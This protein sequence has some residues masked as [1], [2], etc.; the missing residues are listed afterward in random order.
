MEITKDFQTWLI[1]YWSIEYLAHGWEV[2]PIHIKI[3]RTPEKDEKI[4]DGG[5]MFPWA[6][7]K[8]DIDVIVK[9]AKDLILSHGCFSGLMLICG[10]RSNCDVIDRDE[11]KQPCINRWI[12]DE[13]LKYVPYVVPKDLTQGNG[14]HYYF[15]HKPEHKTVKNS[16]YDIEVRSNGSLIV[17]PPSVVINPDGEN[18]SYQFTKY[19][20]FFEDHFP[21][22][23][24]PPLLYR[25]IAANSINK[26]PPKNVF[27]NPKATKKA[28]P[29]QKEHLKKL[30]AS[31]ID[32]RKGDDR[33]TKDYKFLIWAYKIGVDQDTARN[34]CVNTIKNKFEREDYFDQVWKGAVSAVETEDRRNMKK[35]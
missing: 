27:K 34:I 32:C 35:I 20:G 4:F 24:M 30:L 18:L 2:F 3:N 31:C 5:N 16:L 9:R 6:S 23:E 14:N 33:S 22:P 7:V 19:V 13:Y 11:H 17:L 26:V 29:A 10:E 21:L 25:F 8:W 1:D 28:T 15:S 12:V